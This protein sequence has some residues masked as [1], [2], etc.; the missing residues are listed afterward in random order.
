MAEQYQSL[1]DF[2]SF[3]EKNM[4]QQLLVQ[5]YQTLL[6]GCMLSNPISAKAA[7]N[8]E[9]QERKVISIA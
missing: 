4:R 3:V 5:K 1:Y 8:E 7:Y 9:N 6:A 2:W